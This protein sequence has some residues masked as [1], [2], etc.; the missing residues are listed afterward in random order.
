VSGEASKTYLWKGAF[1]N[2]DKQLRGL[3]RGDPWR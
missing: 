1:V 2:C 3:P